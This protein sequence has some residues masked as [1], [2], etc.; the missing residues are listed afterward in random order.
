MKKI[1][2]EV[3][4]RTLIADEGK[5]II[6]KELNELGNPVVVSKEIYLGKEATEE[7]FVEISEEDLVLKEEVAT[8]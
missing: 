3:T 8:E 2:K 4:L 7:D 6:S 5:V 1:E